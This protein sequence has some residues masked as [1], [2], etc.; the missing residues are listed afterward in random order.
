SKV[1]LALGFSRGGRY[2]ASA[3]WTPPSP[4]HEVK[5]W[6]AAA[7][8]ALAEWTGDGRVWG[9]DF[10]P[11]GRLLALAGPGRSVTVVDWQTRAT[12]PD[13]AGEGGAT[14]V[15]FS[16]DGKQLASAEVDEGVVKVWD[17]TGG[18]SRAA[19]QPRHTLRGIDGPYRLAYSPDGRRLAAI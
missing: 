4:T 17:V 7:G 2:L 3:A 14:A 12:V 16:P 9:L 5:V 15:A 19:G 18:D 6:D 11:D 10:S 8:R 13:V 1:P